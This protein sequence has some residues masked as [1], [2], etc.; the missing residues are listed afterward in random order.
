G[1]SEERESDLSCTA[2]LSDT[3]DWAIRKKEYTKKFAPNLSLADYDEDYGIITLKDS[4][5]RKR[6]DIMFND[7]KFVCSSPDCRG[8][9]GCIHVLYTQALP[10]A[11]IFEKHIQTSKK[12]SS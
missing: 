8:K 3:L 1:E 2:W 9:P 12:R 5:K 6:I 11:A 7:G 4:I 10:Q